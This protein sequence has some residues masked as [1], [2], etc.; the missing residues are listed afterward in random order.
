MMGQLTIIA[1]VGIVIWMYAIP[2]YNILSASVLDT[3]TAIA[4]FNATTKDGIPYP[5]LS[6]ILS[7]TK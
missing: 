1:M 7:A 4:K 2:D 3:N 6:T 5:E